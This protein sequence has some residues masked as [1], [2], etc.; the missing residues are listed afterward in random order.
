M[1]A[2][3]AWVLIIGAG[4]AAWWLFRVKVRPPRELVPSLVVWRRVFD[5]SPELTWWEKVR[6]IVSMVVTVLIA[7]ALAIA[8]AR[9]GPK[10]GATSRGRLLIVLDSSWSMRASLPGGGTRWQR[11][12]DEARTL[13]QS[14]G[15]NIALATTAD[16]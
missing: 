16:G 15:D 14:A 10:V 2:W 3:Q 5:Q 7:L 4:V 11:A 9:P 6:R 13:A 1:A 12:V 8:V